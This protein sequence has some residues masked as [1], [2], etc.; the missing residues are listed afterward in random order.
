MRASLKW[1]KEWLPELKASA[2]A[3]EKKLTAAGIEV[4]E[5][6]EQGAG[7]SK[8]VSAEVKALKKH[9]DA[10]SL[11]VA[12]VFD[13]QQEHTVVCGAPNVQEGQK[14]A[15][16]QVGASLPVGLTIEPRKIRGVAS[17]GMIC[18]EEELGLVEKSDGIL[19]LKPRTRPGKAIRD[20]LGLKD[21]I[22]ELSVTPNRADVLSHFGLAR[23]LAAIF[24]LSCKPPKTRVREVE[25]AASTL[26]KVEIKAAKRCPQ[27]KGRVITG[28]KIGPSK[29]EVQQRL[30]AVG[31]RSISN[32]VDATNIVLM[33][34][35][36]PLH[37][38]DLD[39]LHKQKIV[40]RTAKEGETLVTLDGEKRELSTD[41]LVIADGAV[42]I[43]LAGVMGGQDSEV[44]EET[45]NIL[46]ESA[47]FEPQ[48]VRRSAKRHGLHTE[49]SH[50]FE[51][52]ADFD[53]VEIALDRCAQ[54]IVDMAGGQ[55]RKGR[56]GLEKRVPKPGVVPIRPERASMVIGR[57]VERQE[58]R[59]LLTALGLKATKRPAQSSTGKKSKKKVAPK[60]ALFFKVPSWRIDLHREEDL[61]EEVARLIGYDHIPTLMPPGSSRPWD[62]PLRKDLDR[63]A[64]QVLAAE[65]F[66]EAISLAFTSK[67]QAEAMGLQID[68]GV[69]VAN[70]LGEESQLMRMS[71]LPA[72][73]KA[74]RLN[75]DNLP[76]ITDLRLF[77]LG[78]T[79]RWGDPP[80]ALPKETRHVALL[81]RGRR[82]PKSWTKQQE[83]LDAFDLKGAIEGLLSYFR[84]QVSWH[85]AE[86]AWLHPRSATELKIGDESLGLM[87]EAHPAVM[88][89]YELKG[90]PVYLAELDL[91]VLEKHL[92]GHASF[93]SL[94][95]LPPAQRDL[96]FYVKREVA[97]QDV[98]DLINGAG[99]QTLEAVELFDVYE[100]KGVPEGEKSL[101][102]GL[103]FRAPD[104]TL[105]DAEIDKAQGLIVENL[106][107]G[108]DAKIRDR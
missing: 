78:K 16:A 49:A 36:H 24:K 39:K 63:E 81:M 54:L 97:A 74:A 85:S 66:Y 41:D 2:A 29:P 50:R 35:G 9:P 82:Y 108:A 30:K 104:R 67:A 95:K 23:E 65:G 1:I 91:N 75:Q 22:F 99:V 33:E 38:F 55:I 6:I 57:S 98:L 103:T 25:P 105:T 102:V 84:V 8:I 71:L 73:L 61:I 60:D 11:R 80:E 45:V 12:T 34:L 4:D 46:L 107:K 90:A 48:G 88:E 20:V 26:A 89:R 27:Y 77:E 70:P 21:V 17:A 86:Q 59:D 100:G 47:M 31:I 53:M 18:S 52:G 37:A 40:V 10:D 28:V 92:G 43:A 32:V 69:L 19:V 42:P 101:A 72:M 93:K 94:P 13:G 76:S 87:G 56:V 106:R 68:R 15:F 3:I 62:K 14:I 64:R 51:R 44:G 7:L 79:F 83:L 58:I 96:S 5:L